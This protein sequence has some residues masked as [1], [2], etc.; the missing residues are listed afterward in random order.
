MSAAMAWTAERLRLISRPLSKRERV[1]QAY[2][3]EPRSRQ[4]VEI[5]TGVSKNLVRDVTE[6]MVRRGELECLPGGPGRPHQYR[7]AG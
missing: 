7:R 1:Q 3:H 6:E 4:S 5:L 2:D